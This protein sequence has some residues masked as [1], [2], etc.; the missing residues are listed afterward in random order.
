MYLPEYLRHSQYTDT[1]R[2]HFFFL[3]FFH[4][5]IFFGMHGFGELV[6]ITDFEHFQDQGTQNDKFNLSLT[7]LKDRDQ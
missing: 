7:W 6:K 4:F 1:A 2:H 5:R 3:F